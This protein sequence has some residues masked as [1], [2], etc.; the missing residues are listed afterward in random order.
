MG[1]PFDGKYRSFATKLG[2]KT[3][4]DYATATAT[5]SGE[6]FKDKPF[7][8]EYRTLYRVATVGQ[9]GA[10]VVT[11]CTTAALGV[12]ALVHIIPL[13][14]GIYLAV[15]LGIAFA[16]G[17]E[18]VKRSTLAIAS[19]HLLK[20]KTF[21]FVG[22]VAALVM[23]VSIA[24]ALFGAK[25]LPGVV[26]PPP[27]RVTDPAAATALTADI[28]RVQGDIDRVQSG[29]K[30]GKNW[31]AENRT[32]PKLQKDRAALVERRDA[33]SQAAEGRADA[34]H[35][36]AQQERIE[37]VE[38]MQ[39]YSVGAAIV[40]ELVFL[41]CTA[42]CLYYLFRHFAEQQAEPEPPETAT[43]QTVTFSK[44]GSAEKVAADSSNGLPQNDARRPIG[45]D[46]GNRNTENVEANRRTCAHC[47][48]AY[49]YGHA[50]QKYCCD[51]CRV[52]AWETRTGRAL[53]KQRSN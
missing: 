14:W 11:F 33:A 25:E 22:I 53:Q 28:N 45:Y 19:K 34:A 41:L 3:A 17:I 43:R 8:E 21:G 12:F 18:K 44:N 42:F 10:Q 35:V 15:P 2:A 37:K 29:L 30:S 27:G 39:A 36:E 5:Q 1:N 38:K 16:F 51:D 13:W 50:R 48:N 23:C 26:F 9:S 46:Y 31:I 52:A 7:S 32:L 49:T 24:A 4:Q 20:Y 40:A 6:V 47:G